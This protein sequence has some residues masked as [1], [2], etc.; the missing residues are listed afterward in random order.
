[1]GKTAAEKKRMRR[2]EKIRKG[3]SFTGKDGL[4]APVEL[5][6]TWNGKD[7]QDGGNDY[8]RG[9]CVYDC[10]VKRPEFAPDERVYLQFHGVNASARVILN[11]KE[12][13]K[14][15]GGYA[16]FRMDVTDVL[17]DENRLVV[18]VDNSVND[19]VYPQKAD[20]T[21]YGGIYRD[22][23]FLIVSEDHFSL[24]YYG[25]LGLK[26]EMEVTGSD[27]K[28]H[29]HTYTDQA[30][31]DA[32]IRIT[33]LDADGA[34]VTQAKGK[35]VTLDVPRVHLWDGLEDPY[36]Y[37]I[38]AELVRN[39]SVKDEVTCN[40]GIR[41][42]TF[43][44]KDGFHLNGRPYPLHGVSR[45]QDY[46]DLG[47]AISREEHDRDMALIRE[48]GAN[49]IRL[50][51]YQHDQYFYDL[52]DKYG[53]IVWAEIPYI[54]EHLANGNENTVSQMKELIVQNYNHPCIVTWGVSNE[55]TISG[56]KLK[57]QMLAN[58]HV[59]NNLCHQMD[60]T[61]LTTLACFAMC[62]HWH[63]VAHITDLVGWNLYL[64]WYVPFF[65][66]NDLWIR[67]WHFLYPN[68]CLCYSEYGAEGMPNLHSG[69]PRRG[70]NTEEYQCK[71]H[72]YML[73]CFKRYPYLWATYYWNMFDFAA[74][75]RNQGGEPGMNHKGMITFDRKTKKDTF[76]LYKA[77]WSKEPFVHLAGKRYEYRTE[78]TTK[79]TVYSN[80]KEVSLYNN[81]KLIGTKKGEK[82]F[83][84]KLPMEKKNRL[85]V[86]AGGLTD[87]AVIYQTDQP[88]PEYKM[89]KGDSSNWM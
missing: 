9:T 69:R 56:R 34:V 53:M 52:C 15:D 2:V 65:W 50:A 44:P 5:P 61:R 47:N 70:D 57:K 45:H 16:T 59:L 63:K 37:V 13:C 49:T 67:F 32:E 8:Y 43:S 41:T 23:E 10:V 3:W 30:V 18:E 29:V 20:F 60:P 54:S 33:L 40:C 86:K 42:F 17:T 71:Y 38:R 46:R 22:V 78:K 19:R 4:R 74:D 1:M 73:E 21:F 39:G 62:P 48:V 27:A 88:C 51:H 64:G 24:D 82:V 84:F 14:R 6:H 7:G 11:D 36:L 81:G 87:G 26:Y 55:I 58:H 80:F 12:V 72:E 89:A 35:N 25:G 28:V 68:R 85:E 83:H 75:A 31:G 66:L 76:Y 77:Y 79:I